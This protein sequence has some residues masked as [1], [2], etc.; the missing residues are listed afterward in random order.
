ML[1][2]FLMC[3]EACFD[4]NVAEILCKSGHNLS[5]LDG[6]VLHLGFDEIAFASL[7]ETKC[8]V[9]TCYPVE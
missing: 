9:R 5:V 2:D 4:Q 3:F 7:M 6:W 8:C 1:D